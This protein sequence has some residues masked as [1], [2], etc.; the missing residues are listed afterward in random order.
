MTGNFAEVTVKVTYEVTDTSRKVLKALIA[1]TLREALGDNES[2][3]I[4]FVT[5]DALKSF[6]RAE[7]RKAL[8]EAESEP[9]VVTIAG[10]PAWARKEGA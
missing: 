3:V 10:L 6:V 7:V 8:S 9:E 2:T 4:P 1:E 5:L